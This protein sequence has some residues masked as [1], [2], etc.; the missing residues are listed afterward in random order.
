[1]DSL[2]DSLIQLTDR[3]LEL[4]LEEVTFTIAI[5]TTHYHAFGETECHS[6]RKK[7]E[8]NKRALRKLRQECEGV[9][10]LVSFVIEASYFH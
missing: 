8:M 10:K 7:L 2:D 1:M 4:R 6:L 3:E 5:D 9:S